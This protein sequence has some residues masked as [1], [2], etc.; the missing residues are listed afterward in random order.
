MSEATFTPGPWRWEYNAKHKSVQLVGGKPMYDLT[1]MDFERWGMSGAVPRFVEPSGV[2]EGLMLMFRLCD[3]RDWVEPL[4]GREH[5]ADWCAAVSHPD[6]RLMA[7]APELLAA[8]QDVT[9]RLAWL[10]SDDDAHIMA[11]TD[12][13][14]NVI[15]K[16][17][18]QPR[19]P[20]ISC[21]QCGCSLGPGNAGVSS[22]S[23]HGA[24]P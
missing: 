9:D 12:E 17:I 8:L 14:Q 24:T 16:A 20:E 2:G 15:A 13:A 4:K 22:C 11:A 21:S 23:D 7:A 6:A 19:F 10:N 18:G 1:V 5:H 3:R